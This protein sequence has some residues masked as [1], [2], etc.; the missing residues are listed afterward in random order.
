M[1]ASGG[2]IRGRK[3]VATW[4]AMLLALCVGQGALGAYFATR[5][6]A[7]TV[8]PNLTSV[9]TPTPVPTVTPTPTPTAAPGTG[10]VFDSAASIIS[11]NWRSPYSGTLT[12]ISMGLPPLRCSA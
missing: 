8:S 4:L 2:T 6:L 10:L 7:F 9:P 12:R 3:A 1:N 11:V 5:T